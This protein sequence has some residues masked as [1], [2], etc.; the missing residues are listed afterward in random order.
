MVT[1]ELVSSTD[2]RC[3]TFTLLGMA[4]QQKLDY[5][6]RMA[7]VCSQLLCMVVEGHPHFRLSKLQKFAALLRDYWYFESVSLSLF[8][9]INLGKLP[10]GRT[11]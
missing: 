4:P 3:Y 7:C 11:V 8:L 6:L 2:D 9:S 1:C 10:I 5:S